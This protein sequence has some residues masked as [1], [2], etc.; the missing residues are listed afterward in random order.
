M[1]WRGPGALGRPRRRLTATRSGS[2]SCLWVLHPPSGRPPARM[3][4]IDRLRAQ[5]EHSARRVVDAVWAAA[6][7][8][9]WRRGH[10]LGVCACAA[11]VASGAVVG[12]VAVD[13]FGPVAAG[14][15]AAAASPASLDA[16][17]VRTPAARAAGLK[18]KRRGAPT[19]R[20]P[21]RCRRRARIDR[22]DGHAARARCRGA[23]PPCT[24]CGRSRCRRTRRG[25]R[26]R[27]WRCAAMQPGRCPPALRRAA[28]RAHVPAVSRPG[29]EQGA[30]AG[31]DTGGKRRVGP[32]GPTG[33]EMPS[34]RDRSFSG[35]RGLIRSN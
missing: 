19:R 3:G 12:A 29:Q 21:R 32:S 6:R 13:R 35:D 22:R 27:W 8:G 33:A 23:V 26:M 1:G 30:D 20:P 16:L 17:C 15:V 34:E 2:P 10:G 5:H 14:M 25:H 18:L 4:A 9:L 7:G 31:R 11:L 28:I 24:L